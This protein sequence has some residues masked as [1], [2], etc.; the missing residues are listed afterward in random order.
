MNKTFGRFDLAVFSQWLTPDNANML[1]AEVLRNFL[2]SIVI[3]FKSYH[4]V[5]GPVPKCHLPVA[6]NIIYPEPVN[7]ANGF[8]RGDNMCNGTQVVIEKKRQFP[9]KLLWYYIFDEQEHTVSVV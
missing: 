7:I 6:L 9:I 3:P 2:R 5:S 4:A 1:I 8:S